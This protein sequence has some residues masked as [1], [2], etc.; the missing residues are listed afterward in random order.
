MPMG[1]TRNAPRFAANA[2][3]SM[4]EGQIPI[5]LKCERC[6]V[7]ISVNSGSNGFTKTTRF[8]GELGKPGVPS[9][10]TVHAVSWLANSRRG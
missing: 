7:R 6:G 8:N 5:A 10:I 9:R 2:A 1:Q 4:L 3:F